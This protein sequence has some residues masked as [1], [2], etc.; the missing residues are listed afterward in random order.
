MATGVILLLAVSVLVFLGLAHRILDRMHLTDKQALLMLGL[1]L[2]GSF[3]DIP[4]SRYV[5]PV[6]VNV[7]GALV[8]LGIAIYILVRADTPTETTRGILS[9]V[10]TGGVLYA[11]SKL[12]TF[13][14]GHT[15]VEPIYLFGLIAGVVAYIAGRSR[16]AAFAGGILGVLI[17]DIAHLIEVSLRRIPTT[18]HLGGAGIFDTTVIAGL[19]AVALA[20]IAGETFERIGGGPAPNRERVL[21]VDDPRVALEAGRRDQ[22]QQG[23]GNGMHAGGQGQ[24]GEGDGNEQNENR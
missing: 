1:M 6:T 16:R 13:E 15:L 21:R 8:P 9:A 10:V 5:R 18:V 11:V 12:F 7:G 14:E 2:I 23:Q 22:D 24:A 4:I 17:M 20:E 19:V 3:I